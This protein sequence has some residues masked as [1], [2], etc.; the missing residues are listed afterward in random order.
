MPKTCDKGFP[1]P[2]WIMKSI[3]L[4]FVHIPKTAGTTFISIL[5]RNFDARSVLQ[6]D[7]LD[8]EKTFADLE[9]RQSGTQAYKVLMG[10]WSIKFEKF[11]SDR[12]IVRLL[13]LRDPVDHFL[14]TYFYIRNTPGHLQY[15]VA[16]R[17][18]IEDFVGYRKKIHLDNLQTRHLGGVATNMVPGVMDF[19][20]VG[21]EVL[22]SAKRELEASKYPFLTEKFDEALEIL[23]QDKRITRLRYSRQNVS[24]TKIGSDHGMVSAE[25]RSTILASNRFDASL[26]SYAKGL[27]ERLIHSYPDFVS[28]R[29]FVSRFLLGLARRL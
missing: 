24:R 18:S 11:F 23:R 10:H 2:Q 15:D 3:L 14:S 12:E 5:K 27:N 1:K 25:L 29:R 19:D 8:P 28:G 16:N 6:I 4:N 17:L 26:Y 13:F 9:Q 21:D 7:G 22:E 20:I